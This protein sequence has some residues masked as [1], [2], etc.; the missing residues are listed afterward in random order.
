MLSSHVNATQLL[1]LVAKE[2]FITQQGHYAIKSVFYNI[3]NF[4]GSMQATCSAST[5]FVSDNLA[6]NHLNVPIEKSALMG[7]A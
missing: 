4:F 2:V 5:T 6:I 1:V 7:N 3:V